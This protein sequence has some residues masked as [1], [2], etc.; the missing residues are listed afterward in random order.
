MSISKPTDD[1][2]MQF[3]HIAKAW[4][5]S[6]SEAK[7][8]LGIKEDV[9]ANSLLTSHTERRL[10]LLTSIYESLHYLFQNTEQANAWVHKPNNAFNGETGLFLMLSSVKGIDQVNKYLS[11]QR[12]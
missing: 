1:E 3:L 5:L 7:K 8:L 6:D 9:T 11:A 12:N 4:Q 10:V 2:F